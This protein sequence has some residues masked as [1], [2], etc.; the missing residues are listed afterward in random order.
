MCKSIEDMM[1]EAFEEGER[2]RTINIAK[3]MLDAGK[4]TLE[5]IVDIAGLP[6]EEIKTLKTN[7]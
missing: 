3:R 6:L 4:Y 7:L 1:R 2:K 5:E